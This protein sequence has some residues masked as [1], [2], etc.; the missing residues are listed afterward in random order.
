MGD[1]VSDAV[2]EAQ[3]SARR[4]FVVGGDHGDV[5]ALLGERPSIGFCKKGLTDLVI[6][7][8]QRV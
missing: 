8:K 4:I 7:E 5:A 1:Y 6:L 3:R 2:G